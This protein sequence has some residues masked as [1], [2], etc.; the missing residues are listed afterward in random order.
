VTVYAESSAVLAWLF[1]EPLAE[2]IREVLASE[3]SV[4]TSDL[5]LIECDRTVAR[6]VARGELSEADGA[7]LRGELSIVSAQWVILRVDPEISARA[8]YRFP[9]E[10]VRTLDALHLASALAAKA[11]APDLVVLSLDEQVRAN[12]RSLGFELRPAE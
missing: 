7:T 11:A 8:R 6:I 3:E 1:G 5:T 10:P 4:L 9:K 2:D 12:A